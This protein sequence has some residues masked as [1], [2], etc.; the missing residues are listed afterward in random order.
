MRS[1]ISLVALA[2]G[3]AYASAANDELVAALAARSAKFPTLDLHVHVVETLEKGSRLN[4]PKVVSPSRDLTWESDNRWTLDGAKYRYERNHPLS[5][6]GGG[7]SPVQMLMTGDARTHKAF[8]SLGASQHNTGKIEAGPN[9]MPFADWNFKPLAIHFRGAE[10]RSLGCDPSQLK[11]V[12]K[13]RRVNGIPCDEYEY[14]IGESR[15]VTFCFDPKR[16]FVLVRMHAKV[17][18]WASHQLDVEYVERPGFGTV[19]SKWNCAEYRADGTV[20]SK[21]AVELKEASRTVGD[22]D[23]TFD[24]TFPNRSTVYD[25]RNRDRKYRVNDLGQLIEIDILGQP[26]GT[27]AIPLLVRIW[28]LKL[29]V[30]ILVGSLLGIALM[31]LY[32]WMRWRH[33]RTA[34]RRALPT[35]ELP[36]V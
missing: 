36:F 32:C 11:L 24:I 4:G 28:F 17:R 6:S 25:E 22:P 29:R 5:N 20:R 19:P 10:R 2:L 13:G 31:L 9:G 35:A 18:G 23:S 3:S 15:I 33:S 27:T 21:F 14:S 7:R 34:V 16:E 26:V 30:W 1:F 12:A 8:H